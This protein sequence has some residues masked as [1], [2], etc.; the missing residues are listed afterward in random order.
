MSVFTKYVIRFVAVG[1]ASFHIYTAYF[2]TFYPYTQR[3]LPVMLALILTFLTKRTRKDTPDDAPVPFYDWVLVALT[4]P[5]IGYVTFNSD[6]LKNHKDFRGFQ[7]FP[8]ITAFSSISKNPSIFKH[9]HQKH[10]FQT[11]TWYDRK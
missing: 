5:V 9:F 1:M 3:S 8:R 10:T 2:G 4:I 6:Y 7:A 11:V